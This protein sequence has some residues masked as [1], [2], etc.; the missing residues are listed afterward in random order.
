V[1]GRLGV[2]VGSLIAISSAAFIA[3]P[4]VA[5]AGPNAQFF[6]IA[7]IVIWT[8]TSSASRVTDRRAVELMGFARASTLHS[9]SHQTFGNDV[10]LPMS[11][12][13]SV[14]LPT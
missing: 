4:Y 11:Q 2:L 3:M 6:L 5:G 10:L 12:I 9:P 8:T 1:F 7:L 13:Y 14:L